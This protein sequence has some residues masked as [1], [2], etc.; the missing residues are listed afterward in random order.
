M[1][2]IMPGVGRGNNPT[3][4]NNINIAH[5]RCK[6]ENVQCIKC[7]S[8]EEK[9]SMAHF[10]FNCFNGKRWMCNDCFSK[11][12]LRAGRLIYDN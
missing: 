2:T 7:H 6:K 9:K 1:K 3:S 8:V 5:D 12:K 4:W 11:Y 10:T